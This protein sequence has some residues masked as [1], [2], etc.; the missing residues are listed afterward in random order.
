MA[1]IL[2][3]VFKVGTRDAAAQAQR[4]RTGGKEYLRPLHRGL[5]VSPPR[6][7]CFLVNTAAP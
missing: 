4:S 2:M 3:Q 7:H 5:I 6:K 1:P